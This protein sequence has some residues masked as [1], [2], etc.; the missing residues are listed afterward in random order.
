[1]TVELKYSI[2]AVIN[3]MSTLQNC[4]SEFQDQLDEFS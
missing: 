3:R 1:M 2:D 4:V